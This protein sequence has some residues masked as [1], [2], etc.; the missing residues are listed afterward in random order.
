MKRTKRVISILILFFT[1]ATLAACSAIQVGEDF[2]LAAFESKVKQNATSKAEVKNW[3]GSP[4]ST[5]R[6]VDVDGSQREKWIYYYG[7]G[8]VGGKTAPTV[9]LLEIQFSA[10]GKV[11]SY[12]WS[13]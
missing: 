7:T 8:S 11:V 6:V 12:N 1:I 9:K 4:A 5:G 13:Q 2:D 10:A 3:L